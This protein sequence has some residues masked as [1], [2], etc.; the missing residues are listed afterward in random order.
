MEISRRNNSYDQ[1]SGRV[2]DKALGRIVRVEEH[3]RR[4]N[5]RPGKFALLKESPNRERVGL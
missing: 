1:K 3:Q 4:V 5:F 2:E